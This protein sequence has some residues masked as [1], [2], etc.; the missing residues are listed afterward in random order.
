MVQR[1]P[2]TLTQLVYF[3][4]CAKSLNMTAAS[5]ELHVAQSAVSTAI[6]QLERSL[7]ASLFIRQHSKGL[8]LTSAGETL[9]RD[10]QGIFGALTDAIDTIRADQH[11]A[12]GSVT[13]ACF[14]TLSPFMLPQL[15]GG[16]RETHP[17]LE[18]E[19]IEGDHDACLSALRGGRAEIAITY[20]LPGG[21]GIARTVMAEFR[22]HVIVHPG[23]PLADAGTVALRQ[24]ADDPFVL[25]DL[26]S[27]SDYF[28][29]ILRDAGIAPNIRYRSASYETVR[30]MVST[31][32]GYSILNQR[33]RT[34]ETY[35]GDRTVAL[36]IADDA[37]SLSVEIASLAQVRRSSRARAVE[38]A[39]RALLADP[40][41]PAAPIV[42]ASSDG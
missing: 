38:E 32:L 13:V 17:E 8:I 39:V 42:P 3:T 18:V 7:G 22:P 23:H 15:L 20:D 33:P 24:L 2:V 1:F 37:P 40:A 11:H 35:T 4:E 31:G 36:E 34:T 28:L 19:L 5:Q 41:H 26:P 9:L 6:T 30:A 16:L 27:S 21:D 14:N 12:R 10:A 29:A 25:L